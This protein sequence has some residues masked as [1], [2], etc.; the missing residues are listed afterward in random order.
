MTTPSLNSRLLCWFG[1]DDV[2]ALQ[3]RI[4]DDLRLAALQLPQNLPGLLS[5]RRFALAVVRAFSEH[6]GLQYAAQRIG[7]ELAVWNDD[8]LRL[9][10]VHARLFYGVPQLLTAS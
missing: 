7:R 10:G 9:V 8:R 5:Q 1:Y 3:R 6:E 2:D 4:E